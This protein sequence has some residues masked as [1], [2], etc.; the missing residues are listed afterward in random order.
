M[1]S[2]RADEV[3]IGDRFIYS[4]TVVHKLG[5]VLPHTDL[6]GRG[7]VKFWAKREDTG[8]EGWM[9]FGPDASVEVLS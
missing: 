9:V 7:Q 3:K 2:V 1:K 8:T 6:F 4:G 5:E